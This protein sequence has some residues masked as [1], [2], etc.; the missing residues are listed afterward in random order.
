M[1]RIAQ[2]VKKLQKWLDAFGPLVDEQQKK[3]EYVEN[4]KIA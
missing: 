4:K 2:N 1:S 3:G